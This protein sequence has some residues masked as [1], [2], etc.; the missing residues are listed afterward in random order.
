MLFLCRRTKTGFIGQ[1]IWV[2]RMVY[3]FFLQLWKE[4]KKK[5]NEAKTKQK[6]ELK[7]NQGLGIK[8]I[9][10]AGGKNLKFEG[11]F[12]IYVYA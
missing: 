3:W 2:K 10:K 5:K 6:F 11:K 9:T 7:L 4:K 8:K 1:N 12:G